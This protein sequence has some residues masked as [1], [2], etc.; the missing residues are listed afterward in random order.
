MRARRIAGRAVAPI[1]PRT[2]LVVGCLV[3]CGVAWQAGFARADGGTSI[4]S[5]PAIVF[6]QQEFGNTADG[7]ASNYT[8]DVGEG[9]YYC[10]SGLDS[11]W[12]LQVTAGDRL[13]IN[14]EG[15]ADT[16]LT[17]LPVGTNDYTLGGARTQAA[18][19]L[20]SAGM[21]QLVFAAPR[22][23]LMPLIVCGINGLFGPYA[24]TVH[25]KHT[26]RL[27]LPRLG[28]LPRHGTL[29]VAVHDPDGGAITAPGLSVE[30]QI[31]SGSGWHTVGSAVASS[32][33][34]IVT[35]HVARVLSGHAVELRAR[36]FGSSYLPATTASVR[37]RV[38]SR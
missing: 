6:G 1:K 4:A 23:G 30:V 16:A 32:T 36:A 33:V 28:R 3:A 38:N 15:Q 18:Q 13:T 34:A 14:W 31:N 5:A 37:V 25:V 19:Q 8:G 35:L 7:I 27:S 12:S 20:E 29:D 26:V 21:S 17:L 2:I 11:F 9:L 10:T 24:F 22:T